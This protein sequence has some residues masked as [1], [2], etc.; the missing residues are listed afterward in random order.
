M[1]AL[2]TLATA[3]ALTAIG[4]VPGLAQD[5]PIKIG[6]LYNSTGGMSSLD[7]PS[8][9][10][11]QLAAKIVN[12]NGGVLGRQIELLAPDTRTCRGCGRG[13]R[14]IRHDLRHGC[15]AA[16]S[17]SRHPLRHFGCHAP[18]ATAMGG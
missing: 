9:K 7:G 15:G 8:L 5:G 13:D 14:T 10:G 1:K 17:G 2:K 12:E 11:A 6:A 4:M 16:L 18:R 3:A